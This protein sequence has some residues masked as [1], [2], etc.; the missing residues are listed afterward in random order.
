MEVIQAQEEEEEA[1]RAAP[2]QQQQRR[3]SLP[4]SQCRPGRL[5]LPLPLPPLL[6]PPPHP[7]PPPRGY[8]RSAVERN[9]YHVRMTVSSACVK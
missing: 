5:R 8:M 9:E 7:P 6:L 2:M 4:M 1:I 3:L